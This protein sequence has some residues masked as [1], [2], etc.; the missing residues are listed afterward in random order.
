MK[1]YSLIQQIN[2]E[3]G[4]VEKL[5][6]DGPCELPTHWQNISHLNVLDDQELKQLGWL[7]VEVVNENKE[8]FLGLG[9]I[10][11]L[12]NIEISKNAKPVIQYSRKIPFALHDKLKETLASLEEKGIIE[13]VDYPTEWVNNLMIVEKNFHSSKTNPSNKTSLSKKSL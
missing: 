12:C 4:S 5:I 11:G 3:N 2:H 6:I 13:K 10:P 8:V 9:K 7:P 1:L